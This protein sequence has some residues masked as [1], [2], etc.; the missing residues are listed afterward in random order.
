MQSDAALSASSSAR[1][2]SEALRVGVFNVRRLGTDERTDIPLVALLIERHFDLLALVE[3]MH[4]GDKTHS[5]YD[6]LLSALGPAWVGQITESPRPN[7]NTQFAEYYAVLHRRSRV[8]LCPDAPELV[9]FPDADGRRNTQQLP[10]LFLREPAFGCYL[11]HAAGDIQDADVQNADQPSLELT[12]GVYHARWGTGEADEIAKE[13]SHL[14]K[15]LAHQ[16][17]LLPR[18]RHLLLVGDFNLEL[19]QLQALV[20]AQPILFADAG[21]TLNR[22]GERSPHQRDHMLAVNHE[23]VRAHLGDTEVLDLRDEAYGPDAYFARVSDHLPL[24]AHF[25]VTPAF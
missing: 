17:S 23:L 7:L 3:V 9:Y 25:Y 13:V 18:E 5:G 2:S 4:T 12:L 24:R 16:Q 14:D 20:A 6:A 1:A 19:L 15:V 21:T 22:Q 10:D 11:A 8:A